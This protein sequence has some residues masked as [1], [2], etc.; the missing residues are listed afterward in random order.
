M[1]ASSGLDRNA[2]ASNLDR[3]LSMELSK[4]N[5]LVAFVLLI[6]ALFI[7]GGFL[8]IYSRNYGGIVAGILALMISAVILLAVRTLTRTPR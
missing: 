7:L 3:W 6:L 2:Y 8:S 1:A 5:R 4:Q